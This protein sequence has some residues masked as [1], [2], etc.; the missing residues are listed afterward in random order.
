MEAKKRAVFPGTFD[1]FT[2]GHRSLVERAL[3]LVDEVIISI[4]VN[5]SKKSCFPLEKRMEAI[6]RIYE[7]EPNVRVMA[8]DSL[9]VDFARKVD[10]GFIVRGIRTIN[11]F[12]YEKNIA[13]VNRKLTGIDT[14]ILFAEPEYT[15]VSSSIVRELLSYGRDISAFVPNE[16]QSII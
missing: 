7:K 4:G 2:N 16:F 13:D 1:P 5:P 12:E 9:T 6:R 11:D 14:F 15:F 10:A 8:Y 3:R